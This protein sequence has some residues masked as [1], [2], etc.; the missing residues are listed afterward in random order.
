MLRW[1]LSGESLDL[2]ADVPAE[3]LAERITEKTGV[4]SYCQQLFFDHPG[5]VRVALQTQVNDFDR[6]LLIAAEEGSEEALAD[7][8]HS[9]AQGYSPLGAAS[10][11]GD[12][13]LV[14]HLLA[15]RADVTSA[16]L[17]GFTALHGAAFGAA[18]EVMPSLLAARAE[19]ERLTARGKT[20]LC[21]A[22]GR[23]HTEVVRFLLDAR[24]EPRMHHKG[25]LMA[26][27]VRGA[28]SPLMAAANRG[29]VEVV[30]LLLQRQAEV[31]RRAGRD[32]SALYAAA[33]NGHAEVMRCLL[34]FAADPDA[35]GRSGATPLLSAAH[36]GHGEAVELLLDASADVNSSAHCTALHL[37]CHGGY[38]A[39]VHRLLAARADPGPRP[40]QLDVDGAERGGAGAP[41]ATALGCAA[42]V[43][44]CLLGRGVP[45][46]RSAVD[47]AVQHGHLEVARR[48]FGLA[49]GEA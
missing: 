27:T 48:L 7:V 26:P 42:A 49:R 34:R 4:S 39:L 32:C 22:A 1:A 20:C 19:L 38:V 10:Y 30:E 43:V 41:I 36:G 25:D 35:A 23:G 29:H 44:D 47:V 31:E 40:F 37:A 2:D 6:E 28:P 3:E 13:E 8:N 15:A 33:E 11:N 45:V 16:S 5:E 46:D 18:L 17:R 12:V 9:S 24:A 21:I 14:D